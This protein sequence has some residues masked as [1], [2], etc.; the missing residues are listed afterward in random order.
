M[1]LSTKAISAIKEVKNDYSRLNRLADI[2]FLITIFDIMDKEEGFS[3]VLSYEIIEYGKYVA[4]E[5]QG[6]VFIDLN[7]ALNETNNLYSVNH[8]DITTSSEVDARNMFM[9][10]IMF[11]EFVHIAQEFSF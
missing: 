7:R 10:V 3:D 1:E 8:S 5:S 4:M 11:H 9:L 6:R 2:E